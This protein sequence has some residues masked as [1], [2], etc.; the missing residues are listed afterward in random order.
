VRRL[1]L[2][3]RLDRVM[4]LAV[5]MHRAL[6]LDR[7]PGRFPSHAPRA[8]RRRGIAELAAVVARLQVEAVLGAVLEIRDVLDIEVVDV[9]VHAKILAVD[10][11][12]SSP[13]AQP[14]RMTIDD[15]VAGLA[16]P[17]LAVTSGFRTCRHPP[18]L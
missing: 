13:Y 1:A 5:G 15:A 16:Q 12:L 4:H 3:R 11:H 9:E 10:R 18:S 17:R 8:G 6:A 14:R 2:E 7:L